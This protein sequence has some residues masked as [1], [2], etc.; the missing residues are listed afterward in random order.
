MKNKE[1]LIFTT[2]YEISDDEYNKIKIGSESKDEAQSRFEIECM[3]RY[4]RLKA[5]SLASDR[6]LVTG[7]ISGRPT[8][9]IVIDGLNLAIDFCLMLPY[10]DYKI[11]YKDGN[12]IVS[13]TS[14][15]G[16]NVFTIR[17]LS[18]KGKKAFLEYPSGSR[19][20]GTEEPKGYIFR[21]FR[22]GEILPQVDVF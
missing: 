1:I 13:T 10:S 5:C 8:Y 21:K 22:L 3:T 18:S 9:G 16:T 15:D 14:S 20:C 7:N 2:N 6:Y 4:K 19:V 11:L 17:L 12:L